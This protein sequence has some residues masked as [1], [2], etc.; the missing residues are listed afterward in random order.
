MVIP[1]DNQGFHVAT[2]PRH[3]CRRRARDARCG[4]PGASG[5]QSFKWEA[6]L[7]QSSLFL[8]IQHSFRIATE[9]GT[10]AELKGKFLKDWFASVRGMH[11]WGDGDPFLVNYVG[12]PFEGAVAGYIQVHNDPRYQRAEFGSD[13]YWRSRIRALGFAAAYSTQFELGPLS[14]AFIGNVGKGD[15]RSSGAGYCDMVVSPLAGVGSCWPN[16]PSTSTL[17]DGWTAQPI[18]ECC[19][20]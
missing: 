5:H 2:V 7:K 9:Q 6:A 4:V 15:G 11:G 8:G 3:P 13:A 18:R 1:S 19:V 17:F 10:R 14:E 20:C 12:H 16:T